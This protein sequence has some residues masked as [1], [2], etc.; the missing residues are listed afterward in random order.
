MRALHDEPMGLQ[1]TQMGMSEH[2]SMNNTRSDFGKARD[3][4]GRFAIVESPNRDKKH[5]K[6]S[7]LASVID[8]TFVPNLGKPQQQ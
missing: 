6:N 4:G 3:T 1:I 5:D 7:D 2:P 8:T